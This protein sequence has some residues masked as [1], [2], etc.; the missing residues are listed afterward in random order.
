MTALVYFLK[1][2]LFQLWRGCSDAGGAYENSERLSRLASEGR[3][4]FAEMVEIFGH[5]L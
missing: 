5:D 3:E 4:F 1:Q 2:G